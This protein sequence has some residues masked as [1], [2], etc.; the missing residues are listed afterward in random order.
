[1]SDTA[2]IPNLPDGWENAGLFYRRANG[3]DFVNLAIPPE[4]MI[5]DPRERELCR[6]FLVR[7]LALLDA[8]PVRPDEEATT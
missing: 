1:M 6:V 5:A 8:G 4:D 3:W 7:A 2:A